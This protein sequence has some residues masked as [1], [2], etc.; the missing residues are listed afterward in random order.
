M[1]KKKLLLTIFTILC[2]ASTE[3]KFFV[4]PAFEQVTARHKAYKSKKNK[5]ECSKYI[6]VNGNTD[7]EEKKEEL[8]TIIENGSKCKEFYI[9]K[10]IRNVHVHDGNI[11]HDE[12][13]INLGTIIKQMSYGMKVTTI[14]KI[15]NSDISD[16][17]YKSQANLGNFIESKTIIGADIKVKTEV[18]NSKIGTNIIK[19]HILDR[20]FQYVK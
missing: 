4:N 16:G 7:W 1:F 2:F 11:N 9:Y 10:V 3:D 14:T 20:G 19:E 17:Y 5:D 15:E 18:K 12:F 13:D 8:N 6:E